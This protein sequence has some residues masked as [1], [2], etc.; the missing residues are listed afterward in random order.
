MGRVL[1]YAQMQDWSPLEVLSVPYSTTCA[2]SSEVWPL[3]RSGMRRQS[4]PVTTL[5]A[6]QVDGS[7]KQAHVPTRS[8]EFQQVEFPGTHAHSGLP[9]QTAISWVPAVV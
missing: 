4:Q 5:P 3:S 1:A 2:Q 8:V 9:V 6:G 7:E